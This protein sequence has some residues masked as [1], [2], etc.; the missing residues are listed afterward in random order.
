MGKIKIEE[1]NIAEVHQPNSVKIDEAEIEKSPPGA[2]EAFVNRGAQSGLFDFGDEAKAKLWSAL[3]R[4]SYDDLLSKIQSREDL[5]R[6]LHPVASVA[7]DVV[8]T[9]A[10]IP[11]MGTAYGLKAGAKLAQM[12]PAVIKKI[13][14]MTKAIQN[15]PSVAAVMGL[16]GAGQAESGE[17]MAGAAQGVA[18][19]PA[20]AVAGE[21]AGKVAGEVFKYISSFVT[22]IP[23]KIINE[24]LEKVATTDDPAALLRIKQDFDD[25]AMRLVKDVS[26]GSSESY[27][28]LDREGK[29]APASLLNEAIESVKPQSTI[30]EVSSRINTLAD[31]FTLPAEVTVKKG[32]PYADKIVTEENLIPMRA[33]KERVQRAQKM[34]P[35][36][37]LPGS[38]EEKFARD[39]PSA[40]NKVLKEDPEFGSQVYAKHMERVRT[41]ASEL[42]PFWAA[43]NEKAGLAR[44]RKMDVLLDRYLRDYST[45]KID[46]SLEGK[47]VKHFFDFVQEN[48]GRNY[49]EEM[50]GEFV[51]D[52]FSKESTAGSRMYQAGR[53]VGGN[54]AEKFIG[55]RGVGEFLGGMAGLGSDVYSRGVL[56][57][58]L[59]KFKGGAEK[60]MVAEYLMGRNLSPQIISAINAMRDE[61]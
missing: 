50:R 8:G 34:G 5:A 14:L 27:K 25:D 40:L 32:G 1:G 41:L 52:L 39:I 23:K 51:R 6:E 29:M 61:E 56:R 44:G 26:E 35:E 54:L 24:Y 12:A 19:A 2:F 18:M 46:K 48:T 58:V 4:G 10:S 13:P 38:L 31:R 57:N 21:G 30:P 37:V 45:G 20:V 53:D 9:V 59:D 3:G 49:L 43:F 33:F 36:E 60:R 28:I 15:I 16:S 55:K 7:G 22:R 17:R 47:V 42:N 11:L